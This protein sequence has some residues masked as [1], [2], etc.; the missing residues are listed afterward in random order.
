LRKNCNSSPVASRTLTT[1]EA[2]EDDSSDRLRSISVISAR[3]AP[4]AAR[5]ASTHSRNT[6]SSVRPAVRVVISDSPSLSG[7]SPPGTPP[8]P[9]GTVV[10]PYGSAL[11][12]RRP[13]RVRQPRL[14][15]PQLG[16]G[17]LQAPGSE[18]LRRPIDSGEIIED[19]ADVRQPLQALEI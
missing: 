10:H 13:V 15:D 8:G 17:F 7:P 2:Y 14:I 18:I 3:G 16:Q 9:R 11:P 12:P 19:F 1:S 6:S 4:P 5:W